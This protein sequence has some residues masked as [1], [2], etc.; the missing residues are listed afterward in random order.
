VQALLATERGR[1]TLQWLADEG[2]PVVWDEVAPGA[3]WDGTSVTLGV[4]VEDSVQAAL[5]ILHEANHAR[6]DRD[7]R[8]V[9]DEIAD[10][11]KDDYV[12]GMLDEETDGV[13][14]E[15]LG[16]RELRATGVDVPESV[17]E[18]RYGTAYDAAI[19]AGRSRAQAEAEG[20][21][22]VREMFTDG[23][24]VTSTTGESYEDFYGDSW[25]GNN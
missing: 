3:W 8:S 18:G 22:A 14:Q 9:G 11:P 12:G 16:A 15:V 19:E 5:T 23:T 21:A 24:F 1:E 25:E 13:V 6:Y 7:G 17:A 10:L 4:G 2:I 20:F